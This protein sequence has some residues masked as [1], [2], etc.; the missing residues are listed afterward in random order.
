[1]KRSLRGLGG[2][3]MSFPVSVKYPEKKVTQG[4]TGGFPLTSP[5]YSQ[6]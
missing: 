1:M 2:D 3:F 6:S 5:G 4:K